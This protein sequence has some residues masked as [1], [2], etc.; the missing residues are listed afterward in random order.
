M[1]TNKETRREYWKRKW[2]SKYR[3]VVMDDDTFEEKSSFRL[4]RM[5][6]FVFGSLF[7]FILIS[8]TTVL[9]IYSPLRQYI[10]GYTAVENKRETLNLLF[11]V[12]SLQQKIQDNDAYLASIKKVLVGNIKPQDDKEPAEGFNISNPQYDP[13][14]YRVT[15]NG[16]DSLLRR[17]VEQEEAHRDSLH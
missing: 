16:R 17:E 13:K 4:S 7:A 8:L 2:L 1:T 9:I 3:L 15:P 10:L 11:K 6:I 5:N 14:A 12:D